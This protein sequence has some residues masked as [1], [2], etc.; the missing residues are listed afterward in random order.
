MSKRTFLSL[1]I[2]FPVVFLYSATQVGAGTI[3]EERMADEKYEV[4]D[5]CSLRVVICPT[6]PP[7]SP[8]NARSE[9][10]EALI[11]RISKGEGFDAAVAKRIA[12]CESSFNPVAKNKHSSATGLYQFTIGTWRFIGAEKEGLKRENPEDSLRMFIKFYPKHKGW[13]ECKA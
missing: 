10:I 13:W 8:Y 2:L 6:E 3:I 5:V 12:F 1:A 9:E 7:V 11:E 4:P